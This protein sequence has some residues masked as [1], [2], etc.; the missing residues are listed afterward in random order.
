VI[1]DEACQLQRQAV[2]DPETHA[3]V[4]A[5]GGY[6]TDHFWYLE[7]LTS[8]V[9]NAQLLAPLI[10]GVRERCVALQ[11]ELTPNVLRAG[12]EDLARRLGAPRACRVCERI[13]VWERAAAD[14]MLGIVADARRGARYADGDGLCLPHLAQVLSVCTDIAVAEILVSAGAEQT[15]RLA[16]QLSEYVRKWEARDRRWGP[17]ESAPRVAIQKLVGSRHRGR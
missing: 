4:V 8:P 12:A 11:K 7:G 13:A 3:D 1:F 14:A 2:V 16:V 17:E 5:R 10:A 6:C 15:R 9:T